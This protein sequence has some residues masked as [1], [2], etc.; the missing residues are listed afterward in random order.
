MCAQ[1]FMVQRSMCVHPWVIVHLQ[2]N[3]AYCKCIC[4]SPLHSAGKLYARS[5][6]LLRP[7]SSM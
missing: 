4:D 5:S 3:T 7:S 6:T 2:M 1:K